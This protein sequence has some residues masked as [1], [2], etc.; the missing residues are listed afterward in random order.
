[1]L[2]SVCFYRRFAA[3]QDFLMSDDGPPRPRRT[4]SADGGHSGPLSP[5]MAF[6]EVG[7][8][9]DFENVGL[10]AGFSM[11]DLAAL[12]ARVRGYGRLHES[13]LYYDSCKASSEGFLSKHRELVERLG[14]TLVDC[15][16][17]DKKEAIDKKIIVD[18]LVWALGRLRLQPACV[19]LMSSDGDFAHMLSRLEQNGVRTIVIG[20][21]AVLRTVCHTALTLRE[22]CS[23]A[24]AKGGGKEG[25]GTEGGVAGDASGSGDD[26]TAAVPAASRTK[27]KRGKRGGSRAAAA[28]EIAAAETAVAAGGGGVGAACADD[29]HPL[30]E[31][32]EGLSRKRQRAPSYALRVQ[33]RALKRD[34]DRKA[35]EVEKA[36]A[37]AAIEEATEKAAAEIAAAEKAAAEIASAE[38]AVAEVA[39]AE[40][41]AAETAPAEIAGA[42]IAPAEI[43][44]AEIAPA[45]IAPAET[46]VDA[47]ARIERQAFSCPHRAGGL[48]RRVA[49][50]LGKMPP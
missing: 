49:A 46:S 3:S 24:D 41:A 4:R 39:V 45:E 21:S 42:E 5:T 33:R 25:G 23:G 47:N 40:K 37:E 9:W 38:I 34:E 8:Y 20:R 26:A 44:H 27:R 48:P 32:G 29:E 6:A 19:V 28:A 22:A 10:G 15:P 18:C 2:F 14:V 50:G 12:L 1:M 7:L 30:V 13:R 35:E 31:S 43:A 36:A 16:T 17:S 11:A